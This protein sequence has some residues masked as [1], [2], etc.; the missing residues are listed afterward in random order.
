MPLYLEFVVS[1]LALYS[2]GRDRWMESSRTG[3]SGINDGYLLILAPCVVGDLKAIG[4]VHVGKM[5]VFEEVIRHLPQ[6]PCFDTSF[7]RYSRCRR[8]P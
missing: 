7:P 4:D 8:G 6:P 5:I 1:S 3:D 2:R